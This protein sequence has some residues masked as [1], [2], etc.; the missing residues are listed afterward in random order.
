MLDLYLPY[1]P[2]IVLGLAIASLFSLLL[3]VIPFHKIKGA[4]GEFNVR[5]LLTQL[6]PAIYRS[7]HDLYLPRSDGQGTTQVDHV[8]VS[9]FGIFVIETKNYKGWIFGKKHESHWTQK[10]NRQSHRFQNPLHQ[11]DAHIHALKK[12]LALPE[13]RFISG[14][15]FVGEAEL[16]TPM[17]DNVLNR[18]YMNWIKKHE[19]HRLTTDEVIR[20]NAALQHLESSTHRPSSAKAHR[21]NLAGRER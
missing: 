4:L 11:N 6:D 16:K 21:S 1:W 19:Q 9:A 13:D 17:P 8:I 14:V 15:F 18:G 10:L 20:V 3:K 7:F 5:M 12:Y 2:Q